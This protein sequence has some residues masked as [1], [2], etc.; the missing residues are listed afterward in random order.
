MEHFYQNFADLVLLL[1]ALVVV[2]V[3]TSLLLT[4]VG[5]YKHWRWVRNWWFRVIH[6]IAI[7][8][9]VTQSWFGLLC[10]LTI[11]EM[12]LR[13]QAGDGQYDG[14]FMQ[15]WLQRLLYYDVPEWWFVV[16]YSTFGLLVVITW[17]CVPPQK[18]RPGF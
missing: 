5:G 2:F 18:K 13:G 16:A 14:S 8:V 17:L 6:L 12:W 15:Y 7:A 9:I 4:I 11:L 10:P 3:V 1:H